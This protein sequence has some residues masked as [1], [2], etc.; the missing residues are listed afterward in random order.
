MRDDVTHFV[1]RCDSCQS[2]AQFMHQH[3]EPLHSS[4]IQWKFIKWGMDKVGLLPRETNQKAFMLVLTD[5]FTKWVEAEAFAK[6]HDL[7][8]MQFL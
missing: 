6:I 7:E 2:F 8:V 1:G 3:T 4:S 5:Y